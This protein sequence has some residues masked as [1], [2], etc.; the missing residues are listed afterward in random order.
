MEGMKDSK[1][2]RMNFRPCFDACISGNIQ[3]I[4]LKLKPLV[5]IDFN[6]RRCSFICWGCHIDAILFRHLGRR[7]A[8]VIS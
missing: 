8:K 3:P 1:S 5:A 4:D 6:D 7:A 2:F